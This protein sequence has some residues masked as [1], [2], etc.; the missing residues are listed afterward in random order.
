MC[1][2]KKAFL[3]KANRAL[4]PADLKPQFANVRPVAVFALASYSVT[5][6]ANQ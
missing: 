3:S 2:Q 5:V 6:E 1:L 4:I